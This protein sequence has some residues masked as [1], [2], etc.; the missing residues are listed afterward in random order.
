[1]KKRVFSIVGPT[2]IGKTRLAILAAQHLGT[3]ILS[4]DARQ[5]FK[6]MPIGTAAPDEDELAQA[7][8]HFIGNLSVADEY[9]IG[10]YETDALKKLEDLF[11]KYD[12][13][14]LVG[15][16]GMYEKALTEGLN[17][18]PQANGRPESPI[19]KTE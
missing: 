15:G 4:C 13:V 1:M 11:Q 7:R 5:F 8:H 9:S 12:D 18:L 14:V 6:E 3:E 16:S 2:G 10:Q 19:R 17:D